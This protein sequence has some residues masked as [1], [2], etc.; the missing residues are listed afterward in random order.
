MAELALDTTCLDDYRRFLA[1]KQL[2]T[3]TMRGHLAT[4]PDEYAGQL[5]L[6][7][8]R[9]KHREWEPNPDLWDY[10]RDIARIAI[11]KR[12]YAVFADC[13]LGKTL[14]LL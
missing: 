13:G 6:T 9:R 11:R 12:K 10:Q 4:F 1:I 8:G 5:G 14:I 3:Y 2:P 7:K